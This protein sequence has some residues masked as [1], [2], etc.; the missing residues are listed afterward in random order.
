M[1]QS[2][3]GECYK[4][5]VFFTYFCLKFLRF[6]NTALQQSTVRLTWDES[7][8]KRMQNTMRQFTKEDLENMDF[9]DYIGMRFRVD[10]RIN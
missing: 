7:D 10:Y 3:Y 2:S 9:K 6:L 4:L 5:E 8:P 1:K